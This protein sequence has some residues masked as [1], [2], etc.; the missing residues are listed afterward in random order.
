MAIRVYEIKTS[1]LKTFLILLYQAVF[2]S[3]IPVSR[4]GKKVSIRFKDRQ[5]VA[6]SVDL[7]REEVG[8]VKSAGLHSGNA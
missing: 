1:V 4:L 3:V 5:D 2:L 6:K 8:A 7:K